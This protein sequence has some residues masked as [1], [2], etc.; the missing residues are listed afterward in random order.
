[1][2]KLRVPATLK[3]SACVFRRLIPDRVGA[4]AHEI[5]FCQASRLY[6]SLSLFGDERAMLFFLPNQ[7]EDLQ[8]EARNGLCHRLTT[9]DR[10][11]DIV[12]CDREL[13]IT[14]VDSFLLFVSGDDQDITRAVCISRMR[15]LRAIFPSLYAHVLPTIVDTEVDSHHE[16]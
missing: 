12:P 5:L 4:T 2:I 9:R 1:M 11:L 13:T 3:A 7:A 16:A 14:A 15:D 6:R 8:A 10:L